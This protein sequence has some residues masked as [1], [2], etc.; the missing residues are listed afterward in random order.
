MLIDLK[1]GFEI[2]K[3]LEALDAIEKL[4]EL[5]KDKDVDKEISDI[6]CFYI[7][8]IAKTLN[9]EADEIIG[10]TLKMNIKFVIPENTIVNIE[11]SDKEG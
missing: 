1:K 3:Y 11:L 7:K 9:K 5:L 8:N 2:A 4:R 6:K 10:K